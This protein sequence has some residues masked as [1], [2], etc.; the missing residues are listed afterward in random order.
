MKSQR[1]FNQSL[2]SILMVFSTKSS[3]TSCKFMLSVH[4]HCPWPMTKTHFMQKRSVHKFHMARLTFLTTHGIKARTHA[5]VEIAHFP[6]RCII[7]AWEA[8]CFPGSDDHDAPHWEMGDFRM[9]MGSCHISKS[10]SP[11]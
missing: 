2:I 7:R 8:T 6:T 9:G 5:H 1:I 11:H 4:A 3:Q 10:M